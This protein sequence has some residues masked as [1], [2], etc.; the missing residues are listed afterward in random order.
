MATNEPKAASEEAK[1]DLFEDDDEFEEFE[2][3]LAASV[4]LRA[5]THVYLSA[6][7]KLRA[8][9]PVTELQARNLSL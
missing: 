8:Y 4:K 3:D 5:Y 2:I 7:E 1:M 9:T 6:S